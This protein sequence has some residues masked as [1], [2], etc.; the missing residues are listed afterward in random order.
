MTKTADQGPGQSGAKSRNR[1]GGTGPVNRMTRNQ[2]PTR[3]RAARP[4]ARQTERHAADPAKNASRRPR[5]AGYDPSAYWQ[6]SAETQRRSGPSW[7]VTTLERLFESS[8]KRR[9]G[10]P[11]ASLTSSGAIAS[12]VSTPSLSRSLAGTTRARAGQ[13]AAF[14]R[15]C[16]RTGRYDGARAAYYVRD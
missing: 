3:R 6:T 12:S 14:R 4:Q 11:L 13:A 5:R 1:A 7:T 16:R 9:R 10:F 2:S 8:S 15:C